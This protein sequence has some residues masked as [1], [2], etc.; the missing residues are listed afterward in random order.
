MTTTERISLVLNSLPAYVE[1]DIVVE[2]RHD[3]PQT[4][5]LMVRDLPTWDA[6]GGRRCTCLTTGSEWFISTSML[7][8]M[9][10]VSLDIVSFDNRNND[11][12][13]RIQ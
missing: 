13:W 7:D 4:F 6:D 3:D 8:D 1:A 2:L 10:T 11:P 9:D 5:R 12:L